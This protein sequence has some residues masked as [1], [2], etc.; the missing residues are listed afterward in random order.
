MD[1]DIDDDA[2]AEM[3]AMMAEIDGTEG[4]TTTHANRTNPSRDDWEHDDD[5]LALAEMESAED[6]VGVATIFDAEPKLTQSWSIGTDGL[7]STAHDVA[8]EGT[9]TLLIRNRHTTPLP[10]SPPSFTSP[11]YRPDQPTPVPSDWG[12]MDRKRKSPETSPISGRH[13]TVRRPLGNLDEVAGERDGGSRGESRKDKGGEASQAQFGGLCF[14]DGSD[15]EE[16]G[17][18]FD[19]DEVKGI[20]LGK[21]SEAAVSDVDEGGGMGSQKKH[22]GGLSFDSSDEEGEGDNDADLQQPHGINDVEDDR[23]ARSKSTQEA[24]SMIDQRSRSP[25]PKR[26]AKST[27]KASSSILQSFKTRPSIFDRIIKPT[28]IKNSGS[29]DVQLFGGEEGVGYDDEDDEEPLG[30]EM[31]ERLAE[32]RKGKRPMYEVEGASSAVSA[33]SGDHTPAMGASRAESQGTFLSGI[34]TSKNSQS[35]PSLS[36][37]DDEDEDPLHERTADKTL[38]SSTKRIRKEDHNY[39]LDWDLDLDDDVDI[40]GGYEDILPSILKKSRQR[41][42]ATS[43]A[44]SLPKKNYTL[45][46]VDARK[47]FKSATS[48]KGTKLYF[49]AKASSHQLSSGRANEEPNVGN[50]LERRTMSAKDL[51][52]TSIHQMIADVKREYGAIRPASA[53]TT[54]TTYP[55]QGVS[56][57]DVKGK[58][59][60]SKSPSSKSDI[61]GKEN[62]GPW[63]NKYSPRMYID[64]IGDERINREVLTWVKQWDHCVFGYDHK[65]KN[66]QGQGQ[67]GA[68][69]VANRSWKGKAKKN[70]AQ[71]PLQRPEKK[72]LLLAGRAGLGKTTLSHIV[73]RHAGYNVVEI[74]ASDDRTGDALRNKLVGAIENQTIVANGKPNLMV[75]DEIDGASQAGG[76]QNF[77]KLLVDLVTREAKDSESEKQ[78]ATTGGKKK[79]KAHGVLRRPIICICND[80]YVPVLRPLRAIAQVFTFR[81]TAT[82][83][84]AKRLQDIC[85]W[86]GLKTDLRTLMGLCELADG[87]MRSCINTLQFVKQ[88]VASRNQQDEAEADA[89]GGGGGLPRLTMDM[90]STM[91]V[92]LKD[93]QRSLF[94]LWEDIFVL[95]S[96]QQKKRVGY[97]SAGGGGGAGRSGDGDSARTLEQQVA[98]DTSNRFFFRL[99]SNLSANGDYEKIVQGCYETYLQT[100]TCDTSTNETILIDGGRPASKIERACEWL[101]FYDSLSSCVN[102]LHAWEV[103]PYLPVPLI[104]FHQL[105]AGV[106]KPPIEYPRKDYE[107]YMATK[108]TSNILSAFVSGLDPHLQHWKNGTAIA[109][110]LVPYLLRIISPELRGVNIQLIKPHERETLSRLVDVMVSFKLS[111]E[112]EK[113]DDG[114]YGYRMEPPLNKLVE[115]LE[116]TSLSGPKLQQRILST[117]YV[118]KQMIAGEIQ[119]ERMRRA[120]TVLSRGGKGK[121]GSTPAER[122]SATKSTGGSSKSGNGRSKEN[123][124]PSDKSNSNRGQAEEKQNS[125]QKGGRSGLKDIKETVPRDFFGRPIAAKSQPEKEKYENDKLPH[126]IIFKFNEGSSNAVRKPLFVR[127]F[128]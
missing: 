65:R 60:P 101:S 87:D 78:K 72:I 117:T 37:L 75:I 2:I 71:D 43:G 28:S 64:L 86:E 128:L 96:A 24:A 110:E 67:Q 113:V 29:D 59:T 18:D 62:D 66:Q 32:K 57:L 121:G 105:F 76:E 70:E 74:N 52:G 61:V 36:D 42:T 3:E 41:R 14:D 107:V 81:E 9:D 104:G 82:K 85:R 27:E 114:Q 31:L 23:F 84:L 16:V 95:P 50:V 98:D 115:G 39:D 63:V 118:T 120:E 7:P 103:A 48:S 38:P 69:F 68:V 92:G 80:P 100:K 35:F 55:N 102:R 20:E 108:T 5:F 109:T 122:T 33:T 123:E 6:A 8:A 26:D 111:Y 51:L 13:R 127:D 119:R 25:L 17:E 124:P 21:G 47:G 4:A 79:K 45:F 19:L 11:T 15:D 89:G 54:G 1:L 90:L 73:A 49:P 44:S 10:S 116:T 58:Y 91:S 93:M 53:A 12:I 34:A 97:F 30:K 106:R 94:T 83:A 46:P 126:K 77:M 40:S 22:F 99:L 56:L 125:K 112:Q 88:K